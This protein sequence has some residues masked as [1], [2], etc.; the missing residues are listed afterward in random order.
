MLQEFL[1][2]VLGLQA[3]VG[4]F[5]D[6]VS[7]HDYEGHE[8]IDLFHWNYKLDKL[9]EIMA[10]HGDA[11]KPLW[12]TERA[13]A[14]VRGNAGF[15]G[16]SQGIRISLQRDILE[17]Y[18]ITNEHNSHYYVNVTGYSDVPTF[19]FSEAGPHPAALICR[20]RAAMTRGR[21]FVGKVDFGPTGNKI[22]LGLRYQGDDGSTIT[23]RNL[24]CLDLP[25]EVGV[26]GGE[27]LEV[28][29]S[30]GNTEA[31]PVNGGKA[32]VTVSQVPCYLRLAQGQNVT[33]RPWNFGQNIAAQAKF[34]YS[35]GTTSDPKILTDGLFQGSNTDLPFGDHWH[36]TYAGKVF[37]EKP[38]TFEIAFS[39]PRTIEKVIFYGVRA[40]NPFCAILDYDLQYFDSGTWKTIEEVRTPCPPS[41]VV[42]TYLCNTI[43]W[44]LDNNF[45]VHQFKTPVKTNKL[46]MV[47]RRITLGCITDMIVSANINAGKPANQ[48]WHASGGELEF[49]EIEIYGPAASAK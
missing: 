27:S 13:M 45:F 24:G 23:L 21:K 36:G 30:F 10:A 40:D 25:L 47:V 22:F 18:G 33:I 11:K 8:G 34:T 32:T 42:Q 41:D 6:A 1:R 20:I 48:W 39:R 19:V 17:T 35:G 16:I 46:R 37:N 4:P 7:I 9:R 31:V 14:G 3:G 29:D 2:H 12:Q 5:V 15:T 28:V 44:Y 26:T 43:M 38:E 49:R